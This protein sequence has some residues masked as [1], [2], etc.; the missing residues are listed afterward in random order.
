MRTVKYFLNK[1][2]N[3]KA[4]RRKEQSVSL[5]LCAFAFILTPLTLFAQEFSEDT[6]DL[7]LQ[8]TI[9]YSAKFATADQLDNLYLVTPENEI[10]KFDSLG[11]EQFRFST[12]QLGDITS[13]DASNAFNLLVFYQ[14]FNIVKTLDRT[15]TESGKFNLFDAGIFQTPCVGISADKNLWVYDR[16]N[17]QLKKINKDGKIIVESRQLNLLFDE[18]LN[19]QSI[20]E[21]GNNV[22]LLDPEFGIYTFDIFGR[23]SSKFVP[24]KTDFKPNFS[25]GFRAD[26]R[27]VFYINEIALL[28]YYTAYGMEMAWPL[29][30]GISREGQLFFS[31]NRIFQ[32]T[33]K[34]VNVYKIRR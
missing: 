18:S 11:N 7:K 31:G 34:S 27:S 33:K 12:N 16:D 1:L 13:F 20:I 14:E 29:P 9:P 23:F 19:P 8:L 15:L 5:R 3:V 4:Q 25:N 32:V 2:L 22:Y 24:L 26:E 17:F 10:L 21:N 28:G 6:L 30:K